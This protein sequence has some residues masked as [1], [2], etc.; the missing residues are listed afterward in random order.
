MSLHDSHHASDPVQLDLPVGWQVI[1]FVDP[2]GN[3]ADLAFTEGLSTLDRPELLLWARPTEGL[4]PGADWLLTHRER[5]RLLNRWAVELLAGELKPGMEREE[6][7]DGGHAV[8]RFRFAAAVFASLAELPYLPP[9]SRVICATWSLLRQA[10]IPPPTTLGVTAA[11]RMERWIADAEAATLDWK[12]AAGTLEQID[13]LGRPEPPDVLGSSPL[14]SVRSTSGLL[15]SS[16]PGSARFGPMTRWVDARITQVLAADANVVATFLDRLDLAACARCE[17][18]LLDDL[19]RLATRAH[20]N[21]AC[22]EASRAAQDLGLTVTGPPGESTPLW[23]RVAAITPTGPESAIFAESARRTALSDGL[24]VLLVSAVLAD[25]AAPSL[26]ASGIGAWAWAVTGARVPGRL[27]LARPAIRQAARALLTP[28]TPAL[29]T[30]AVE[31]ARQLAQLPAGQVANQLVIGL[32]TT[33]AA[34]AQ[35][36][37]LLRRD[38]GR[39]LP[40]STVRAA[41]QLGAQLLTAMAQP[42]RFPRESWNWLRQALRPLVPALPGE[43]RVEIP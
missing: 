28:A 22:R 15:G 14:G 32:Q 16:S 40:R 38:Q 39:G 25:L 8:A 29:L 18:C 37:A 21:G 6:R 36:G 35:P 27:W 34:S 19:T 9:G 4:D 41:D 17:D 13:Y 1:S 2:A 11:R 12:L 10:L 33:S 23:L 43:L 7:F 20:H 26:T 24:E 5:S 42:H 31:H 3:G 30:T